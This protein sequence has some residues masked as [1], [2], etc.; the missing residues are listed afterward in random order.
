MDK[1]TQYRKLVKEQLSKMAANFRQSNQWEIIEAYDDER[2]QY[3]LF[4]DGWVGDKRDYGCFMHLEVK[5]NGRIWLRR[6]GTDFNIGQELLDEGVPKSDI[7]LGFK[8][9]NMRAFSEFAIN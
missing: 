2:G 3:L 9:P 1:V 4:T 8:S 6:D 7:V 5:D